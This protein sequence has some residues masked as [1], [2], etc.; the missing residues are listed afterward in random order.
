MYHHRWLCR[1]FLVLI[2]FLCV[3]QHIFCAISVRGDVS[4]SLKARVGPVR[5]KLKMAAQ[6]RAQVEA[7]KQLRL[8]RAGGGRV[9]QYKVCPVATA[10]DGYG[11]LT[12]M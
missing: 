11:L 8:A 3:I 9:K 10:L 2:L 1:V 6:K 4:R 5:D 12:P 7:L